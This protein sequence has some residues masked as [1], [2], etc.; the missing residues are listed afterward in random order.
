MD[1]VP[2]GTCLSHLAPFRFF[3]NWRNRFSRLTTNMLKTPTVNFSAVQVTQ[4]VN[5]ALEISLRT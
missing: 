5:L 2:P 3:S 4:M 1:L